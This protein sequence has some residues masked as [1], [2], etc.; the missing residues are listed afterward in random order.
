LGFT[1]GRY[2]GGIIT[3]REDDNSFSFGKNWERYVKTS[4]SDDRVEIARKHLLAFLERNDLKGTTFLD[5]GCGSG[6]HSYAAYRA[7]ATQ[8]LS[9]DV[10]EYSVKT[11]QKIREMAG[12]PPNW[13]VLHGSVLDADFMSTI[14]PVDIV[15]SWGVLHH[16]G[17]LWQAVRNASMPIRSGG[18]FYIALYEKTAKSDYWI[19]IKKKYNSTSNIGKWFME[20]S[21]VSMHFVLPALV[22]GFK[23]MM[24][25]L[26]YVI[27]YR[28]NRGMSFMTDIRDWL[29]GWPY[30]PATPEEVTDYCANKLGLL[31][32]KIKTGEA[33][34]EYLFKKG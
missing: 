5:I 32:Q 23:S 28:E 20:L 27:R 18:L 12:N 31:Q 17:N 1:D 8:V 13:H 9:L 25:T 11:T 19:R 10:D 4:F 15:Y 2:E 30:E 6:I 33:N 29:G 22:G 7:G 26:R 16:T 3:V 21:H 34:I 14:E 24:N